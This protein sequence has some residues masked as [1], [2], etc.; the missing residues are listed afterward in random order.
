MQT[1]TST[2]D[3]VSMQSYAE[4]RARQMRS[5]NQPKHRFVCAR[6]IRLYISQGCLHYVR[7][8]VHIHNWCAWTNTVYNHIL[9]LPPL[10]LHGSPSAQGQ[11]AHGYPVL[12]SPS[13]HGQSAVRK[14]REV[15]LGP[16]PDFDSRPKRAHRYRVHGLPSAQGPSVTTDPTRP[17]GRQQREAEAR[18]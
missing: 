17:M 16:C 5:Y 9:Q 6:K 14:L 11:S 1:T 15:N 12:G 7:I 4:R 18:T 13:A 8:T 10:V 3:S 2:S